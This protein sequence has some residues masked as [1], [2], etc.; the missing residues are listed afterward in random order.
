M[1]LF[2]N[3]KD[4]AMAAAV[5]AA[6]QGEENMEQQEAVGEGRHTALAGSHDIH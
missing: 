3:G 1:G 6:N 5:E 4:N 2:G